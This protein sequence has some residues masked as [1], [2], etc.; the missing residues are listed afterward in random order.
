[1]AARLLGAVAAALAALALSASAASAATITVTSKADSGPGTIRAALAG[2]SNGDTIVI[3]PGTYAVTS[4]DLD[5]DNAV[6]LKGSYARTTILKADGD[7]RVLAVTASSP[8]TI[9]GVTVTGGGGAAGALDGAGIHSTT[10]LTLTRVALS[11][12]GTNG[13]DGGGLWTSKAL[14]MS[15][16]LVAHDDAVDGA[17]IVLATGASDSSIVNST[18]AE[19]YGTGNG[20]GIQVAATPMVLTLDSVT[21][22]YNYAGVG[23]GVWTA[24]AST[25]RFRNSLITGNFTN[26]P[27][28]GKTCD[29]DPAAQYETL[30]GNIGPSDCNTQGPNDV[31]SSDARLDRKTSDYGGPTD[32]IG[33]HVGTDAD[34]LDPADANCQATDQRGVPRPQGAGCAPGAYERSTPT[35]AIGPATSITSGSAT[36]PG[37]VDTRGIEGTATLEYGYSS[38]YGEQQSKAVAPKAQLQDVSFHLTDLQPKTTYHARLTLVTGDGTV[39][40]SDETFTTPA[41]AAKP[42]PPPPCRVPNLK[43]LTLAQARV[44]LAHA[45]CRLGTVRHAKKGPRRRHPVVVKQSPRP[46]VTRSNGARVGVTLSRKKR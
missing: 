4:Q 19:N 40:S 9:E 11:G 30:G 24:G 13:G 37:T 43:E 38:Y 36:V 17:G 16:S 18:I 20:G 23:S 42:P 39:Q 44:E 34:D 28:F 45:H 12:N 31:S 6:T 41:T 3:P 29:G 5:V 10:P 14:Q 22:A 2:S 27:I 32:T 33:M 15:Q 26:G 1:M 25:T 7:N 21:L 35:A 8:V 46:F